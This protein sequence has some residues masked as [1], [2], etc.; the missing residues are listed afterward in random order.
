M[1]RMTLLATYLAEDPWLERA[2]VSTIVAAA[3]SE[4]SAISTTTVAAAAATSSSVGVTSTTLAFGG[5]VSG[6]LIAS[7]AHLQALFMSYQLAV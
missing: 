7:I 1:C 6:G 2:A 5:E 3:T 4:T